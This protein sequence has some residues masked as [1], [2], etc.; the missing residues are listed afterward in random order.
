MP[1]H[2]SPQT[3]RDAYAWPLIAFSTSFFLN[4]LTLIFERDSH[5]MQLAMLG[6]VSAC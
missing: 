3:S 5:K 1:C 4:L 2:P 6:A